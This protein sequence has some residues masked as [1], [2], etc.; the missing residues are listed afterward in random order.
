[1][2]DRISSYSRTRVFPE[3]LHGFYHHKINLV[4]E[5]LLYKPS[6]PSFPEGL[7]ISKM[8]HHQLEVFVSV[9]QLLLW[10]V[11]CPCSLVPCPG[12]WYL[13]SLLRKEKKKYDNSYQCWNVPYILPMHYGSF[14]GR[15]IQDLWNMCQF[16]WRLHMVRMK[17][18]SLKP[19]WRNKH[20]HH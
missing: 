9:L 10:W 16:M 8:S 14:F 6:R 4:S 20:T 17:F 7:F 3:I 19:F 1:M 11:Q 5:K 13:T 18:T 15:N 12:L 2:E